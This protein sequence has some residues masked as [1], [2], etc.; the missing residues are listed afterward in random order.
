[1]IMTV[2]LVCILFERPSVP[3]SFLVEK[4]EQNQKPNAIFNVLRTLEG[5]VICSQDLEILDFLRA[6]AWIC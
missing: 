4:I 2:Y 6:W 1:M 5:K 3:N